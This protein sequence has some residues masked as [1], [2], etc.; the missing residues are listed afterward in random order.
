M[1]GLVAVVVS[2]RAASAHVSGVRV[3][4]AMAAALIAGA[5]VAARVQLPVRR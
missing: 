5:V 4:Y 2:P 3:L 1:V